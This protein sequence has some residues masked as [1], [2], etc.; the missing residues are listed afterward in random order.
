MMQA[1]SARAL[2]AA[3]G[4]TGWEQTC[5]D[6]T[7]RRAAG[8]AFAAGVFSVLALAPFFLW[9]VLFWT[10]PTLIWLI[11]RAQARASA[12]GRSVWRACFWP[13]WW[14]GFGYFLFGL[15][16]IGEAFLVESER[17]LWALPFAVTLLPAGLAIFFGVAAAIVGAVS[18]SFARSGLERVL[19]LALAVAVTEWLRGHIFT[20]FPWNTLGY[21]LTMPQVLMQSAS[22]I[23]IYGLTLVTV[24][25]CATP[26]VVWYRPERTAGVA[27]ALMCLSA[28][29]AF[30]AA[31]LALIGDG[32]V[33]DV[34]LRIV[35]PSIPQREKWLPENQRQI[36][37]DH[38]AL[39]RQ[40][41]DGTADDAA[42]ASSGASAPVT[43]IIWPEAA[44]PFRPLQS[45]E[46][47]A[48][49][50][51]MLPAN[52]YLLSGGLRTADQADGLV[53]ARN[54]LMVFGSGGRVSDIYDKIHLVPFGE[55]LPFRWVLERLG[56]EQ[57]TRQRGGFGAGPRPRPTLRVPGLP[58]IGPLICY[59]AI[60]PTAVV[61]GPERPGVLV[62][63]TND[64]WFGNTTGPRQHFHQARVRAVEEGL[65]LV[66]AANNGISGVI[67]PTGTVTAY[68]GLNIKGS[69]DAELPQAVAP[70]VY[71]RFGDG[72][73]VF[74]L[75][76][77][78]SIFTLTRIK[79]FR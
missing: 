11:D 23:G 20:G 19:V 41:P 74:L 35:Q 45:P 46:A 3:N 26:W 12:A 71:A 10:L 54:S 62:N 24:V 53:E 73:F 15:F 25:V 8:L 66:R 70:T 6:C 13:G 9:P 67:G 18:T 4:P 49:I 48:A 51:D 56:L 29:V 76:V 58:P 34:R 75:L 16:W 55:Y 59:E 77:F 30:G 78:S 47:M 44:M 68:L 5:A 42:S 64:G 60:F 43:H 37:M 39:S 1:A 50:G 36:F 65:P 61:Q 32:A 2:P 72:C 17:F 27:L 40:R 14:F 21:A 28:M 57:L 31:R 63:I 52:T 38:L 22:V 33:P 7:G 69:I 79:A